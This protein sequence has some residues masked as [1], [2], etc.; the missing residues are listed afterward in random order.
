MIV[1][2]DDRLRE[3]AKRYRFVFACPDCVAY[4]ADQDRCTLGYPTEPHR[5]PELEGR[6]EVTFC[7]TF[8]LW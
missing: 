8:E 1:T 4:D 5:N 2:I 6:V 7:K 3:E